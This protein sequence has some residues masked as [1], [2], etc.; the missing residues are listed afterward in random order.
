MSLGISTLKTR[1]CLHPEN[2]IPDKYSLVGNYAQSH[3]TRDPCS[4]CSDTIAPTAR[5]L[6]F[7]HHT[8]SKLFDNPVMLPSGNVYDSERLKKLAGILRMG[9][10]V[11]LGP[12]EVFDPI[13]QEIYKESDF[14]KMYPT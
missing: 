2:T 4:V 11:P 6:P 12:T 3:E 9:D 8:E 7:A 13:E 10:L 14:I 1:E 5:S